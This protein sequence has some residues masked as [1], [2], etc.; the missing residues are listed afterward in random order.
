MQDEDYPATE[1]NNGVLSR[2]WQSSRHVTYSSSQIPP[3]LPKLRL[4]GVT[5]VF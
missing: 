3:F 4:A 5:T 2:G 1:L